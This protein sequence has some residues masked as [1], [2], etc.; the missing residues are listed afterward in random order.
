MASHGYAWV[1]FCL[2]GLS[3]RPGWSHGDHGGGGGGNAASGT[4]L[5][6]LETDDSAKVA[7]DFYGYFGSSWASGY[8]GGDPLGAGGK[9]PV[10]Y[11]QRLYL[12]GP[13]DRP[14]L[15]KPSLRPQY[16][17]F[18]YIP[19]WQPTQTGIRAQYRFLPRFWGSAS[20]VY[21]S[22][23]VKTEAA[24]AG[25]ALELH[26]LLLK[27]SP[28]SAAG[29]VLTVGSLDLVGAF[30][31]IFDFFPLQHA[32][33]QGMSISHTRPI[34]AGD[35]EMEVSAGREW[36][37]RTKRTVHD[38]PLDLGD[39]GTAQLL[40]GV[41]D[42]VHFLGSARYLA[43]SGFHGEF[44]AGYQALPED[45]TKAVFV[46]ASSA[47]YGWKQASGW[48]AGIGLGYVGAA[49]EHHLSALHGSGDV[50]MAW[51]APD[52]VYRWHVNPP[53][54]PWTR[55]GS[56]LSLAT[57]WGAFRMGGAQVDFGAWMQWRRPASDTS[58]PYRPPGDTV[59]A[60][61]STQEFRALRIALDPRVRLGGKG[62]LGLRQDLILYLDPNAH[63]NTTELLTDE[64]LRPIRG[65]GSTGDTVQL[66][67][68]SR[69]EREAADCL[70]L[71]P[72]A[73]YDFTQGFHARAAWSG[74]WY[75]RAVSRQGTAGKFH[76]NA[77]FSVWYTHSFSVAE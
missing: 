55:E 11:N 40:D 68:P 59:D 16:G 7:V 34:G 10:Y 20:L 47:A 77:T 44:L 28:E 72:Y 21:S 43:P 17:D 48:Q 12:E 33:F 56:S 75:G 15:V 13:F 38:S 71:T 53:E 27:W 24:E 23:P 74:A 45:S 58:L 51:S 42:R 69:W 2:L 29:L 5:S 46:A 19:T 25:R 73:Q 63:A 61:F 36:I 18:S 76:G 8:R 50:R 30:C 22:D 35:L 70:V 54:V 14:H 60:A 65:A 57:Y 32:E 6:A 39:P 49:W 67:G 1:L 52:P 66:E 26:E 4:G 62:W 31:P 3:G 64:A 41:R 37:G 9:I